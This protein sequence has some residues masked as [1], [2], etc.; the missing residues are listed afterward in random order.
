MHSTTSLFGTIN[1]IHREFQNGGINIS[2]HLLIMD[3]AL[4]SEQMESICAG[5]SIQIRDRYMLEAVGKFW[6]EDCL[7]CAC[8]HCRLGEL[9]SKLYY[10]QS[11][12][13]CA[14]DYLRLFGSTGKCAVCEKNIPAFELVMRAKN[15]VYHLQCFACQLCNQRFCIGDKFYLCDNKIL[16]QYD[17]EERLALHQTVNNNQNLTN[18][19]RL[20]N[21]DALE[22]GMFDS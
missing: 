6:H 22:A 15:N 17:F 7:K 13:L 16:C 19:E 21:F 1:C 5:C 3:S 14:R 9:G 4:G 10:K 12:M 18:V 20:K 2:V 11:M 8:C